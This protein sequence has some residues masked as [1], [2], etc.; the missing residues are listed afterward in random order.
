MVLVFL[1]APIVPYAQSVSVPGAYESGITACFAGVSQT[2]LT[3][4]AQQRLSCQQ[5]FKSAPVTLH[6]FATPAFG[7]LGYGSPPYPSQELVTQGNHSALVFF[8]GGRAVAVEEV[9]PVGVAIQ[10]QGV[11]EI[12]SA[13][14]SSSDF[15]FLNITVNLR[16]VGVFPV[17]GPTVW[18]LMAGFSTNATI[19][20]LPLLSPKLV[21]NCGAT[22]NASAYC[23]VS[24]VTS[25]NLPVNKSVTFGVEVRGSV[26]GKPFL[27][28][29][30]FGEDY[31]RGGVGPYWVN[32][33]IKEVDKSR[34][35]PVLTENSTLDRFAEL[36]FKNASAVYQ[37]SDY[38][39][40]A[41][42]DRFFGPGGNSTLIG[43][44]LLYPGYSSPSAY[45]GFL[46]A[47]AVGHWVALTNRIDTQFGYFVGHSLYYHVSVPCPV[48]E[49][50]RAGINITQ[51]FQEAGCK[52]TPV[53]TTWL[54]IIL[55]P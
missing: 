45:A 33:F 3:L 41:D 2:N 6:G 47:Y 40:A 32:A 30:V 9:G 52:T 10:P 19:G 42:V 31:P 7:M 5:E 44:V 48:Y 36:R 28:R 55:G 38:G 54:V 20:G 34:G 27:F 21:G 46:S 49:I 17:E 22:W 1:F 12:M 4:A 16:N 51:F 24:E 29:E 25:N 14:V 23:S 18:I 11:V 26:E 8:E 50:P 53:S 43:E 39:L 35:G 15:G 37:I 13:A